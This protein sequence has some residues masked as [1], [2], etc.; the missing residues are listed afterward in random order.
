M[1]I[2]NTEVKP[3]KPTAYRWGKFVPV[4]EADLKGKW[5]EVFFCPADL[6]FVCPTELDDLAKSYGEFQKLGAEIHAVSTDTHVA[7]KAWHDTS[8]AIR[9]IEFLMAADPMGVESLISVPHPEGPQSR[10]NE[11]HR[12]RWQ[13]CCGR[14]HTRSL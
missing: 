9:Q 3:F 4:I 5:S 12:S 14:R 10:R 8:P 7:H 13:L 2:I 1:S 11:T 6:T